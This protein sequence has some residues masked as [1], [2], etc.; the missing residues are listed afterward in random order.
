MTAVVI[1]QPMYFPWP[2]FLDL[3]SR[4]DVLIW[5]DDVQFSKGSFT[6]RVQVKLPSGT[7]WLTVPLAGKGKG[8][9]IG[10]LQAQG[11]DWIA[12]HRAALT[13]SLADARHGARAVEAFDAVTSI[14]GQLDRMLVA[15]AETVLRAIGASLPASRLLASEMNVPG[16]SWQ[17]VL[18]LV[19]AVGGT[20]YYSAAGGARYISHERFDEAGVDVSYIDY[21]FTPWPQNHGGFT[22]YVTALDLLAGAGQEGHRH[23]SGQLVPWTDYLKKEGQRRK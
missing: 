21:Q 10:K 4:A 13:Q 12:S 20:R 2:G 23:L 3:I 6:N 19:L 8:Q 7:P 17:R 14:D 5:L 18:D 15:S 11:S 9:P 22:P 1:S 16:G